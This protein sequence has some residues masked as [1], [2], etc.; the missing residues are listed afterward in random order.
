LDVSS[1]GFFFL[2]RP[3]SSVLAVYAGSLL[4]PLPMMFAANAMLDFALS[5]T[6]EQWIK[7]V[8]IWVGFG[9]L[10]GLLATV[11]FPFRRPAGPFWA[12]ATGIAGSTLGLLGLSWLFPG[13]EFNPISPLGFLAAT[14]GAFVL[15]VLYRIGAALFGKADSDSE[16]P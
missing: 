6:A 9:T 5:P 2:T 3:Q 10:V 15:L 14:V 7:V 13:R 8:L 16:K 12:V 1:A 11:I 4:V